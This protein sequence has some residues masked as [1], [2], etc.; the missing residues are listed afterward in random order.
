MIYLAVEVISEEVLIM[1]NLIRLPILLLFFLILASGCT[2]A[3]MQPVVPAGLDECES[4]HVTGEATFAGPAESSRF[5]V[6]VY[7]LSFD[8]DRMTVETVPSK[9]LL[10]HLNVTDFVNPPFCD[11]CFTVKALSHDPD[12][13]L[14][15]LL[16][17]LKNP[18][19]AVSGYDIRLILDTIIPGY[20]INDP[21][22]GLADGFTELWN[23]YGDTRNQFIAFACDEPQREVLPGSI[24]GRLIDLY[25][26]DPPGFSIFELLVIIDASWPENCDEPYEI[27]DMQTE[28]PEIPYSGNSTGFTCTVHDWYDAVESVILTLEEYGNP[29]PVYML[30]LEKGAGNIY[31]GEI[32]PGG[33]VPV[34]EYNL[35]VQSSCAG[36]PVKMWQMSG[37]TVAEISDLPV[38]S[39]FT[40]SDGD[41]LLEV[42]EVRLEWEPVVGLEGWY[43]IE[44]LNYVWG[45]DMSPGDWEWQPL[46]TVEA[47]GSTWI[48]PDARYSG[49]ASAI[50]YR[51]MARNAGGTSPGWSTDTGYPVPREVGIAFW[52]YADD[53]GGTNEWMEWQQA[54][55]DYESVNTFWNGYGID[56]VMENDS[57]WH[58]F[59]NP[60]WLQTTGSEEVTMH[61]QSGKADPDT[62]CCINVYYIE[63][64]SGNSTGAHCHLFCADGTSDTENMYVV[65]HG[66]SDGEFDSSVVHELGH[67]VGRLYDE[68]LVD[69][70]ANMKVDD[71]ESCDIAQADFCTGYDWVLFCDE[72]GCYPV[73]GGS[74]PPRN[75][76]W[77]ASLYADVFDYDIIDSQYCWIDAWLINHEENYPWP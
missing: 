1:K 49:T 15:K 68:Y 6:G 45:P 67:A 47:P 62:A 64:S 17:E 72:E 23:M 28:F 2:S 3:G 40:A 74:W 13:D 61:V 9:Y 27:A 36:N 16:V 42:R 51:I 34:G 4:G 43:D 7:L 70:N 46:E 18:F 35:W 38:V 60:A 22:T 53:E 12:Q 5:P 30:E 14:L 24:H 54:E 69:K 75:L 39:G 33:T 31:E 56:Y 11:D 52:T 65:I 63:M 48:D 20:S 76:M 19:A 71:N 41:E 66:A 44:R 50:S 26:P 58:Y 21:E 57:G 37:V 73:Y 55:W 29:V 59:T 32:E 10:G 8:I 77:Y 25:Y